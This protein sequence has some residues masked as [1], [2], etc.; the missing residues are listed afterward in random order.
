MQQLLSIEHERCED[1][2]RHTRDECPLNTWLQEAQPKADLIVS[3]GFEERSVGLLETL[4]SSGITLPKVIVGQYTD[5]FS[6]NDRYRTRFE[7]ASAIVSEGRCEPVLHENDGSWIDSALRLSENDE[8]ILDITALSNRALFA[9]LDIAAN[10]GRKVFI[11]YTEAGEYYPKEK[12]M[13]AVA[14]RSPALVQP[15]RNHR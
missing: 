11:A 4:G 7:K 9:A 5:K 3:E 1:Y 10:S 15:S 6:G 12:R 14:G 13:E 8:V 2:L